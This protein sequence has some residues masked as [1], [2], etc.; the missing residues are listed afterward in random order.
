MTFMGHLS[1]IH[2]LL[3]R[4]LRP[5]LQVFSCKTDQSDHR[6]SNWTVETADSSLWLVIRRWFKQLKN[7]SFGMLVMQRAVCHG[8]WYSGSVAAASQQLVIAEIPGIIRQYILQE[9]LLWSWK[10]P[11]SLFK[12]PIANWQIRGLFLLAWAFDP[13]TVEG[14]LLGDLR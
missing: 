4:I 2:R 10:K 5:Y 11:A 1:T 3:Y 14:L 8:P 12:S 7:Y 9:K 13:V 6:I